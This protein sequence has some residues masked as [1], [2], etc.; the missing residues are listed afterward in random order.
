METEAMLNYVGTP[1]TVH[2]TNWVLHSGYVDPAALVRKA[3]ELAEEGMPKEEFTPEEQEHYGDYL[4]EEVQEKLADILEESLGDW[5]YQSPLDYN[6][7]DGWGLL[8]S[9]DFYQGAD[10][11]PLIYP[12]LAS[13]IGEI[14]FDCAAKHI[15]ARVTQ[16]ALD[17]EAEELVTALLR[18]P[19]TYHPEDVIHV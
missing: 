10:I 19:A 9:P 7:C 17:R 15:L 13:A 18:E 1:E 12:L 14:E 6:D 8:N 16:L 5:L 4:A 11:W 3:T 2:F